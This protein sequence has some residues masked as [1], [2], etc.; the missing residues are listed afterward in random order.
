M[1][2]PAEQMG[3]PPGAPPGGAPSPEPGPAAASTLTPEEPKGEQ[4]SAD[5]GVMVALRMLERSLVAHGSHSA[6]GKAI[7][8]AITSLVTAFGKD[9]D[10]SMAIMPAE[11]KTALMAPAGDPGGGPQGPGGGGSMQPPGA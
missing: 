9:E 8:K 6:K 7:N 1:S 10:N 3:G 2:T 5:A 4:A 11:V